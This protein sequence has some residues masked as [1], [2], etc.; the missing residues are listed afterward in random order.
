MEIT[1]KVGA[2]CR[3]LQ[4]ADGHVV[5]DACAFRRID[6]EVGRLMVK[7]ELI[8]SVRLFCGCCS[9][10]VTSQS[11]VVH[12]LNLHLPLLFRNS[13]I[14]VVFFYTIGSGA[15]RHIVR[16]P[17]IENRIAC[18]LE[19]TMDIEI[20]GSH[21]FCRLGILCV[22]SD[23]MALIELVV[24]VLH[25]NAVVLGPIKGKFAPVSRRRGAIGSE[26]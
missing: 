9:T 14:Y 21:L 13:H 10:T 24:C 22:H 15:F 3:N 25:P 6:S 8:C 19:R 4:F 7:H 20:S 12:V 17:E 2:V 11:E 18:C 23:R 26:R 5:V 1:C 16:L